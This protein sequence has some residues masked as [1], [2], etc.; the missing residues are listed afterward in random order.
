VEECFS[1]KDFVPGSIH[2]EEFRMFWEKELNSSKWVME[3]IKEGYEMKLKK[4]QS[5]MKKGITN[6]YEKMW[7]RQER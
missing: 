5:S 6:Q 3:T 7:K 4:S 1:Q 2:K